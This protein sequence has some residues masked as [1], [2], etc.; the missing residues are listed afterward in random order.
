[1]YLIGTPLVGPSKTLDRKLATLEMNYLAT[2]W[3]PN[4]LLVEAQEDRR[5]GHLMGADPL[6]AILGMEV[7]NF[8]QMR[9]YQGQLTR[10]TYDFIC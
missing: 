8:H 6:E 4:Y 5:R 3:R 2:F 9:D 1:M 7:T 10:Y